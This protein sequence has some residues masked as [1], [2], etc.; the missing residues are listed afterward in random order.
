[1]VQNIRKA[2]EKLPKKE[3]KPHQFKLNDMVL[4]KDP[5]AAVFEPRYQP[6]FRVT[7][8]FGNNRIEV[9]DE[10][11]HKSVRRSVHVKYIDPSEKVE[12]QLPSEQVVKN[13]GRSSKL[14]L[15]EKDILD[16]HFDIKDKKEKGHSSEQ[17]EVMEIIDVTTGEMTPLNI[18]FQ[19][20]SRNSLEN[21]AGEELQ[22]VG[23]QRSQKQALDSE[24]HSKVSEYREHSQK[25]RDNGKPTAAEMARKL[26]KWT[27]SRNKHLQHSECRED[28]QNSRIKQPGLEEA[29]ANDGDAEPT[30]ASSDF[31]KHSQNSLS[32]GE[33][34]VDQGEAKVTF[35]DHDGQCLVTVSEFRELSPNSRVETE[36][37]EDRQNKHHI[38]P[39]C[40]GEPSEYSRDSLG[41]GNNVSV[42]RFS[43]FKSMSQI[44]GLT[45]TWQDKEEGNPTAAGTASNAKVNT[46]P[47]RTE[48]NFFL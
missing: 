13:Y 35:G 3:E 43:W 46:N 10:R 28:S 6:N 24:L 42:P 21:A 8:I 17:T 48:F 33:P 19:E 5:D 36:G 18:D 31:S 39:V 20:H 37:S 1:M 7:A 25:S 40:S 45:A 12:K 9:Q 29:T 11:G 4:V 47:V 16:L 32:N 22:L 26:M 14:L 34:K 15:A 44:V 23:E 38:M 30:A 2:R 41:V 27:L